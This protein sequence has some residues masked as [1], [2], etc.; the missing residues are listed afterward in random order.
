M[1]I[2]NIRNFAVIA[3][4]DHGK[5][6][7]CDRILEYT[8]AIEK[9][10]MKDQVL[11]RMDLE[12]ERGITIK[13]QPISFI[14]QKDNESYKIHLID[15]PG[16]ID[17]SYEVSRALKAVEGAIL[18]VDATQGV[19]AQT[20]T[21]LNNA[22]A[23]NVKIIPVITKIDSPIANIDNAK[24]QIQNILK[25]R[26]REPILVSGKTGVGVGELLDELVNEVP[27]PDTQDNSNFRG[28]VFDYAYSQHRGVI[29]YIRAID[30]EIKKGNTLHLVAANKTF[31]A[32]DVGIFSPDEVSTGKL[33]GGEIG[34]ITSGL[35]EPDIAKPGDTIHILH[36]EVETLPG[37]QDPKPLVWL[38]IYPE[39][40]GAFNLLKDALSRL[41]L[42][43]VSFFFEED[44]S[45]SFGRGFQCGF[46]GM[47]HLDIILERLKREFNVDYIFTP[48][49]VTY[50][51]TNQDN[52]T[53]EIR[54]PEQ[55]ST[56]KEYINVQE[57]WVEV[58]IITPAQYL[59]VLQSKFFKYEAMQKNIK[60]FDDDN[61]EIVIEMPLRELMRNFFDT[62]KNI[63]S[64][65]ASVS[66]KQIE[67]KDADVGRLDVQIGGEVVPE[68]SRILSKTK[69]DEEAKSLV[70]RIGKDFPRRQF[71]V[72]IQAVG[73]G[74]II[75]SHTVPAFRKDVTAKLYGGDITRKM[76]LLEK[77]KKGK[78]KMK[79]TGKI[80]IP[81]DTL[82]NVLRSDN[83]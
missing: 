78:K 12:R 72:K 80:N 34:Y 33:K 60:M 31:V 54:S 77:Q 5:S 21:V 37:Y 10:N 3:H 62:V 45:I 71:A 11:D 15:T 1:E 18:I 64:G 7:L 69:M 17:F 27:S 79:Q 28:L 50:K 75:S 53:K 52:E 56:E 29:L 73:K 67:D 40:Q 63:T 20:I 35:K 22:L 49:I 23:M 82:I 16:H 4:V 51:V 19:Q 41:R 25:E 68:F 13:M 36:K 58:S 48:P 66:Y 39:D 83:N 2:K 47:L 61:Q 26:Y 32:Q 57:P 44:A 6:T 42:S 9:R 65:Y 55:F 38:N 24:H 46:L 81:H 76:K 59:S 8:N 74:R 70:E 30:G 14:H 43:D